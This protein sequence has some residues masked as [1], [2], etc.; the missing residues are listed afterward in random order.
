MKKRP[1][2]NGGFLGCADLSGMCCH[3]NSGNVW[4]S[5]T[6]EGPYLVLW[7]YCDPVCIDVHGPC[8]YQM[9]GG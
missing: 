2:V 8:C 4:V 6:T 7:T 9:P 5:V 3:L 1:E